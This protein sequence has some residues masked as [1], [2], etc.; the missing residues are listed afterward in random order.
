MEVVVEGRPV[1]NKKKTKTTLEKRT[2]KTQKDKLFTSTADVNEFPDFFGIIFGD[3][4]S[5]SE[6]R[7][8]LYKSRLIF[9]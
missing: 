2:I 6:L 5:F 3:L 4:V 1:L 9:Y 8:F 7:S